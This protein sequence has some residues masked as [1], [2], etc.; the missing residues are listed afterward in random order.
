MNKKCLRFE[1]SLQNQNISRKNVLIKTKKSI[2][3]KT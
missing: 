1:L 2:I 3:L